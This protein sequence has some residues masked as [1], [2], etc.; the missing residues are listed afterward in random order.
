MSKI[1]KHNPICNQAMDYSWGFVF[2]L[3]TDFQAG[4]VLANAPLW[5]EEAIH[6]KKHRNR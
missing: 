4:L 2:G 5:G 3:V 6:K 1:A